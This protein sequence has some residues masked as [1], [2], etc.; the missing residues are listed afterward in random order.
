MIP[1][2]LKKAKWSVPYQQQ[3]CFRLPCVTVAIG[4][5]RLIW[6]LVEMKGS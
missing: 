5:A 2:R 3:H 1:A 4:T 6:S